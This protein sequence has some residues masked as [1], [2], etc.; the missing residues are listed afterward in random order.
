MTGALFAAKAP[1]GVSTK[2]EGG[3]SWGAYQHGGIARRPQLAMVG[4]VP[5]A[6]VPLSGGRSI[7]VEIRS[8]GGDE[9]TTRVEIHN[10]TGV[11]MEISKVEEYI[12]SDERII[13][14]VI[15]AM[16][17]NLKLRRSIGDAAR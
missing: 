14:V 12:L 10:E 11:T 16:Q 7:P 8:G 1:V 17:T 3:A 4:E 5:E 13:Q 6:F 9:R 15:N 2:I